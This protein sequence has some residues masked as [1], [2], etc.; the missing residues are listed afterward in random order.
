LFSCNGFCFCFCFCSLHIFFAVLQWLQL[1]FLQLFLFYFL[2]SF[3]GFS[4]CFYFCS[5]FSSN[6]CCPATASSSVSISAAVSHLLFGV[7]QWLR[8]CFCFCSCFSSIFC[9][10]AMASAFVT[11]SADV[12]HI[13]FAVLQ[14]LQLLFLQLF[15]IYF[16]L[17]Y[18][19]FSFCFCF[20]SC[21]SSIS[22]VLKWLQ[23][24]VYFCCCFSSF[25]CCPAVASA[26][27]SVSAAVSHL[28][29]AVLQ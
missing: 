11:V 3:N 13:I 27:V 25:F 4:L 22:S 18:N 14:W 24:L 8:F 19:G 9:C 6:F 2:L 16:L 21:F 15:L 1:L 10:P 12:S 29:Y 23:V 5:C 26:L 20:C 7:L 28:F 17:S